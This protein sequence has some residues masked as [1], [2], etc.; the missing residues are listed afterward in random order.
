MKESE[1]MDFIWRLN[2]YLNTLDLFTDSTVGGMTENDSISLLAMPGGNEIP[3][4]DGTKDKELNIQINAKSKNQFNSIEAL[5][6]IS[7]KLED[8]K[9]DEIQSNN[10]TF[11]FDEIKVSSYVSIVAEDEQGSFIYQ[12]SF[13]A[14][15]TIFG[16]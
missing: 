8:L 6:K 10:G 2:E 12:V 14:K 16:G 7:K 5:S 9:R 13:I 15:I 1:E 4:H 3:F 11:N